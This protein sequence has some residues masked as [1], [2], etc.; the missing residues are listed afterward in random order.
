MLV[1]GRTGIGYTGR[2]TCNDSQLSRELHKGADVS[3][4]E[5]QLK[6]LML[7]AL[8]GDAAAY[9]RLLAALSPICGLITR[10]A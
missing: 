8:A 2:A 4:A 7:A 3:A 1:R 5:T 9:R 6:A 10:A